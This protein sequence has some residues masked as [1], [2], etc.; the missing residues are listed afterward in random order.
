[1]QVRGDRPAS[2]VLIHLSGPSVGLVHHQHSPL[3]GWA[4]PGQAPSGTAVLTLAP[5]QGAQAQLV[6]P[7]FE[8]SYY[9]QHLISFL[10]WGLSEKE[11]I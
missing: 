5:Y 6:P 7:G 8:Y 9:K 11:I 1:M 10:S 2:S 4:W 3:P